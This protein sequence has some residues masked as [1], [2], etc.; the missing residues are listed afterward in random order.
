MLHYPRFCH[1]AAGREVPTCEKAKEGMPRRVK[2]YP[3]ADSSGSSFMNKVS[4]K[5]EPCGGPRR[6]KQVMYSKIFAVSKVIVDT[7]SKVCPI[8]SKVLSQSMDI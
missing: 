8:R 3:C 1:F 7:Q 2:F 6:R 4:K 5:Q